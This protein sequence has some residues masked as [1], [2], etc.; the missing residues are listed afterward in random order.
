MEGRGNLAPPPYLTVQ[1][2]IKETS[3]W[4]GRGREW[5]GGVGR[6]GECYS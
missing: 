1:Q 2:L 5:R 4:P 6:E 3:D